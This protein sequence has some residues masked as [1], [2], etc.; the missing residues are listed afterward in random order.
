MPGRMLPVATEGW[1]FILVPLALALGLAWAGWWK[2][3]VAAGVLAAFMA[4][5][6]RDPERTAPAVA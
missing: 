5:F 4:F 1:G 3:A 6:F 2:L